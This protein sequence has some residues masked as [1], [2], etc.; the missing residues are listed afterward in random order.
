MTHE[1]VRRAI[2]EVARASLRWEGAL[3]DG[4]LSQALDSLQRL[5]LAV[6]IEDRFQICLDEE[7]ERSISTV[8]ALVDL[9]VDLVNRSPDGAS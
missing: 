1:E 7:A 8:D 9:V 5:T 2:E 6:A 4:D 3:P